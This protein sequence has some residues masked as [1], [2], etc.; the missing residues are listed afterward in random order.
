MTT[1]VEFP[2]KEVR[3]KNEID[4]ML[5]LL[6]IPSEVLKNC[7]KERLR[8]ILIE[9]SKGPKFSFTIESPEGV[10]E[11]DVHRIAND[12]KMGMW[13]YF[14]EANRKYILTIALLITDL[15]KC[16]IAKRGRA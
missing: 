15:C 7:V 4:K 8:P 12:V 1:V 2:A 11:E 14:E 3:N 16:E 6:D 9:Y 5:E 13:Q 10:A